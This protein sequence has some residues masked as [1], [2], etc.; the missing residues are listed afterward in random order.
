MGGCCRLGAHL[1]GGKGG[2]HL[3]GGNGGA[4]LCGGKVRRGLGG[5][6]TGCTL[7]WR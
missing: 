6:Q 1:C 5:L 2:A 3:C 7:V 4:H